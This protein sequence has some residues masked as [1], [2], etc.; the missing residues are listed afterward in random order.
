MNVLVAGAG[1]NGLLSAFMLTRAGA[2]VTLCDADDIPNTANASHGAHRLIH[3]W[4]NGDMAPEVARALALW[5]DLLSEVDCDG[6]EETGV[7]VAGPGPVGHGAAAAPSDRLPGSDRFA[8]RRL[9]PTFGVLMAAEIQTALVR[10]L[11]SR[12]VRLMPRAA[13]TR[14]D[15][16][17]GTVRI[18]GAGQERFDAVVLAAGPG[19]AGFADQ[20]GLGPVRSWRCHVVYAPPDAPEVPAVAWADLGGRD[21][22]G[23]SALRGYPAKFGCGALS[24]S[25]GRPGPDADEVRKALADAYVAIHPVYEFLYRGRVATNA[26]TAVD[27]TRRLRRHGRCLVVTSDNG[28]GFKYAPLV[29]TDVCRMVSGLL[30]A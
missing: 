26:W 10:W 13:V 16:Q 28:G 18:D 4:Q 11:V 20:F 15:A 27:G 30:A 2:R 14:I 17:S 29:A 9:F 25:A 7:L 6:F 24:H 23:M 5:R 12:D 22:W 8:M 1:I 19:L 21:M 3:P